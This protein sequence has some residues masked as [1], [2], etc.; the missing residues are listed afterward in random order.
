MGGTVNIVKLVKMVKM[1]CAGGWGEGCV[2]PVKT[3]GSALF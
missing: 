1:I 3:T 2:H